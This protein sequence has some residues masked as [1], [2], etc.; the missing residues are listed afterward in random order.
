[1]PRGLLSTSRH[2]QALIATISEVQIG[3]EETNGIVPL[4]SLT[5]D[6]KSI[7]PTMLMHRTGRAVTLSNMANINADNRLSKSLRRAEWGGATSMCVAASLAR[8]I[9]SVPCLLSV[10][11]VTSHGQKQ[12][13]IW[14]Y[15]CAQSQ[16]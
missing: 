16:Y 11:L 9:L 8:G 14:G 13:I 4:G 7:K 3:V 1:M 10:T 6:S 2:I 5:R 12:D 15:R